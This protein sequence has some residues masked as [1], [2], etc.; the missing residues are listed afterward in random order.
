MTARKS[1][2]VS[3][4][5]ITMHPHNPKKYISLIKKAEKLKKPI[6]V[7]GETYLQLVRGIFSVDVKNIENGIYG[8]IA[9]FTDIPKD[10]NWINLK[11][12]SIAEEKDME[13][14]SIPEN[15]KPNYAGFTF[16]FF[17]K[18][19]QFFYEQKNGSFQL[20]PNY[21]AKFLEGLFELKEIKKDFGKVDVTIIPQKDKYEE[22]LNIFELK[23]LTIHLTRPNP[24]DFGGDEDDHVLKL[25]DDENVGVQVIERKAVKGKSIKPSK[26]TKMLARVASTNGYVEGEGIAADGTRVS[27]STKAHPLKHI[28][29]YDPVRSGLFEAMHAAATKIMATLSK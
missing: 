6:R 11:T 23:H 7:S 26:N 15:M 1:I 19:H 24:D 5:N 22:I 10:A 28:F 3:A 4:L 17:P 16:I 20:S 8:E 21:V 29:T 27:D 9:K 18:T 14:V 2:T 13:G 12:E 25:L